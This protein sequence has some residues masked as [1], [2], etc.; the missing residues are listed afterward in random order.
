MTLSVQPAVN[1]SPWEFAAP[2]VASHRADISTLRTE[3][4]SAESEQHQSSS[5]ISRLLGALATA[6]AY[7]DNQ[8]TAISY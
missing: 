7:C 1:A 5:T 4:Q 8:R 3:L 6:G 2:R